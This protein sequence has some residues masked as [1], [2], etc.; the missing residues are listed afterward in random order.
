[1]IA[2]NAF[3][4]NELDETETI[5]KADG[6]FPASTGRG[7]PHNIEGDEKRNSRLIQR[8]PLRTDYLEFLHFTNRRPGERPKIFAAWFTGKTEMV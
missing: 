7:G 4:N 5:K 8:L 3:I 6:T 1:M 2:I